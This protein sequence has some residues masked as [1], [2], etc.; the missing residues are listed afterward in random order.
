MKNVEVK[1]EG[2]TL[3]LIVDVSKT[4]GRSKSGKTILVATTEG[5]ITLKDDDGKQAVVVGLNVYRY[6]ET[7]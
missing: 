1:T 7:R 4:F 6:P 5:N 2:N 3:T